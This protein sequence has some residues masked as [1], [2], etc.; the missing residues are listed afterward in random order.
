MVP[1]LAAPLAPGQRHDLVGGHPD[2]TGAAELRDDALAAR[3]AARIIGQ[4]DADRAVAFDLELDL[5]AGHEPGLL[6]DRLRDGDL[7]FGGDAHG[8]S[9]YSCSHEAPILTARTENRLRHIGRKG[10]APARPIGEERRANLR[11]G[12]CQ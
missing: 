4:P 3:R 1:A 7:A 9:S 2:V 5:G 11:C 6:A 8:N 10:L 12:E